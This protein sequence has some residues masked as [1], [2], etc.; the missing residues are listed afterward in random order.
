MLSQC[1]R[2][3]LSTEEATHL[4]AQMKEAVRSSWYATARGEGITERDCKLI[5][6]AFVSEGFDLLLLSAT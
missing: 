1:A 2:F 4:I 6:G 3:L 5:A